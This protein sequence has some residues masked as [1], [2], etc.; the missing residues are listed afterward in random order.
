MTIEHPR[1]DLTL[2]PRWIGVWQSAPA[3]VPT[4]THELSQTQ[5]RP[6]TAQGTVRYR[7]RVAHGG[8]CIRVR[9]SNEYSAD[10]L[11][12]G[13]A[14]VG[15][16]G[17]GFDALA[18]SIVPLGFSGSPGVCV[19][20]RAPAISD[21]V[22]LQVSSQAD[23]VV[24]LFL[25]APVMQLA[26]DIRRDT[27]IAIRDGDQTCADEIANGEC[28]A[29]R[30]IMS[31]I[32]AL[33]KQPTAVVAVLG[34]SIV[35]GDI[36]PESGNRGW[37]GFLSERLAEQPVSVINAGIGGNRLLTSEPLLGSCALARLDQD[38]F[39]V[40]GLT[41][42]VV[43]EGIND[44]GRSGCQSGGLDVPLVGASELIGALR[45]VIAR[46]Q[47]RSVRVIGATLLPFAGSDYFRDD[48]EKVRTAVNRWIRDSNEF[49]AV[50]D[51]ERAMA[52]SAEPIRL[53]PEYDVGDHLHPSIEGFRA[54]ANTVDAN[55]FRTDKVHRVST[56]GA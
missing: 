43:A 54:M 13:A 29:A 21:P 2:V 56:R 10:P 16:A 49:D 1:T 36:D 52:G 35:D 39:S 45:Q 14:S 18:G 23:L 37:P 50:I 46:A 7:V 47:A 44:I 17:E 5:Y 24:S 38:V 12:I 19:P 42:L 27:I 48:R 33:A 30:P 25:T 6:F 40:P 32:Y 41:H 4:D 9:L 51:F 26:L 8:A 28:L 11:E 31:A 55:L 34:D 20:G 22:A 53:K 15:F 3:G